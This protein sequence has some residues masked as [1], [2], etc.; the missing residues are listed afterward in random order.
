MSA[1][2]FFRPKTQHE[3]K[4]QMIAS[5]FRQKP[6]QVVDPFVPQ[7]FTLTHI[8]QSAVS[9]LNASGLGGVQRVLVEYYIFFLK[10]IIRDRLSLQDYEQINPTNRRNLLLKKDTLIMK[11]RRHRR[12][13][14][15]G[16]LINEEQV[17]TGDQVIYS[18]CF[19]FEVVLPTDPKI[20]EYEICYGYFRQASDCRRAGP[21]GSVFPLDR[22]LS[23]WFLQNRKYQ[24]PSIV[25]CVLGPS[26]IFSN[27]QCHVFVT[28][29]PEIGMHFVRTVVDYTYGRTDYMRGLENNHDSCQT[30]SRHK[31][32]P[33]SALQAK[34]VRRSR[35]ASKIAPRQTNYA[36]LSGKNGRSMLFTPGSSAPTYVTRTPLNNERN[37]F[38]LEETE[39]DSEDPQIFPKS[40]LISSSW[41]TSSTPA[42]LL[43][44][45]SGT[46]LEPLR[47]RLL[48]FQLAHEASDQF[49]LR[50]FRPSR[51]T[52]RPLPDVYH[53]GPYRGRYRA[54]STERACTRPHADETS[55]LEE[56][57]FVCSCSGCQL[58]RHEQ[59]EY[60]RDHPYKLHYTLHD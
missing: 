23:G 10:C 41:L 6:R 13:P 57:D 31:N 22:E 14:A 11:F 28:E 21:E 3:K 29:N 53:D 56:A 12:P 17:Y 58:T 44:P 36:P 4:L 60:K 55:S 54:K 46:E 24:R 8:G 27:L 38:I 39:S 50:H 26:R 45:I 16:M 9:K 42:L 25:V 15:D 1:G 47:K 7:S 34:K 52:N 5:R 19:C 30:F 20:S 40:N 49:K 48:Q 32:G 37:S 51:M 18:D 43:A 33:L 2:F 59:R 35:S